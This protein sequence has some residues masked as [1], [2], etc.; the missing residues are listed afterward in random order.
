MSDTN[1]DDVGGF[2]FDAVEKTEAPKCKCGCGETA[3]VTGFAS[4][5][6]EQKGEIIDGLDFLE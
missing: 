2:S 6:C 4:P 1:D 3:G 5:A